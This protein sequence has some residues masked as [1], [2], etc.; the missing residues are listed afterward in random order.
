M[1]RIPRRIRVGKACVP[2]RPDR[3]SQDLSV[4]G[5]E[6]DSPKHGFQLRSHLSLPR[7]F[8]WSIIKVVVR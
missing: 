7:R 3:S 6:G 2:L 1:K 4:S 5:E 8:D